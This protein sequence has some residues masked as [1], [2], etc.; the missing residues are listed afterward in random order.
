MMVLEC[1]MAK[2]IVYPLATICKHYGG[3]LQMFVFSMCVE[4]MADEAWQ[5]GLGGQAWQSGLGG[6]GWQIRPGRW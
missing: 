4:S 5:S 1:G 3:Y 2:T 6:Q